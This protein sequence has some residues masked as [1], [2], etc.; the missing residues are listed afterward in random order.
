[1]TRE[2]HGTATLL[3]LALK[4]DRVR[5]PVWLV[6]VGLLLAGGGQELA[7]V[8][9][10]PEERQVRATIMGQPSGIF[11]G[12][13]GYGLDDY[14]VGA[15]MANEYT[16]FIVV[17][18]AIMAL[19]MAVRHTRGEE[20]AGRIELLRSTRVGRHAAPAA[21]TLMLIITAT[22]IMLVCAGSMLTLD[23]PVRDSVA[24]GAG[25]GLQVLVFGA[26]GLLCAQLSTTPRGAM[27][28]G[29][30]VL[31]A[32][33]VVRGI[34]DIME[35]HGSSLSWF[36]PIAW[37]MQTRAFV[38]LRWW[39]LLPAAG[40]SLVLTLVAMAL[41]SRRD[42]DAGLLPQRSG[43][44]HAAGY[45]RGPLGLGLRLT[46]TSNLTWLI[47]LILLAVTYGTLAPSMR[48]SFGDLPPSYQALMGGSERAVQG[49]LDLAMTTLAC[50]A[51]ALAVALASRLH[52]E[53]TETRTEQVLSL[54]VARIR[55]LLSWWALALVVSATVLFLSTL[56]LAATTDAVITVDSVYSDLLLTWATYLPSLAL[57]TSI[58][59]LVYALAPRLTALAWVPVIFVLV[60]AILG[61]LLNVPSW[62][63]DLSPF[64]HV[65]RLAND[66][67]ADAAALTWVTTAAVLAV[68][69]ALA[70]FRRR[71]V[72]GR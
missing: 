45:L 39:P 52:G 1:M 38:E 4:R 69:L 18:V 54:P 6:A 66:S 70:A 21:T 63:A 34:G 2:L 49:Y 68:A 41:Q 67:A 22:L 8:F 51:A 50:G 27:G 46:R 3:R 43:R 37:T 24:Y 5:L 10:S 7:Q 20:S 40:L 62:L 61:P 53:E 26:V 32:A 19:Q 13:P 23:L 65:A 12:G 36:S 57:L 48:D 55:W 71:D 25:I 42:L 59:V 35:L 11:M 64:H 56:V 15:M 60:V 9:S 58:A 28:L 72:P 29:L 16:L 44:A 31:G 47:A 14:T 30:A 33:V 17:A